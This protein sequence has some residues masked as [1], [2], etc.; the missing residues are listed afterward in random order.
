MTRNSLT[1]DTYFFF[2]GTRP[3]NSGDGLTPQTAWRD[4]QFG[5][6]CLADNADLRGKKLNL[7]NC[8]D[9][10]FVYTNKG[11][12]T[13]KPMIGQGAASDVRI[14]GGGAVF[15]CTDGSYSFVGGSLET[16][17]PAENVRFRL[18]NMKLRAPNG[19][20]INSNG[21]KIIVWEDVDFGP[22]TAAHMNALNPCGSIIA[23]GS[24]IAGGFLKNGYTISGRA[25][26]HGAGLC[27]A[28]VIIH[29]MR[30][31]ISRPVSFSYSF[32]QA[33]YPGGSVYTE[34]SEYVNASLVTGRK[35]DVTMG[36]FISTLGVT[37][38]GTVLGT[39]DPS[40]IWQH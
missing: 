21:S 14:D 27:S 35:W 24:P 2:D 20:G 19:G 28:Y 12:R 31:T 3:D 26:I 30:V 25:A 17:E 36:G 37:V 7:K 29:A 8:A 18:Q 5:W 6:E 22:M 32:L 40:S 23:D 4:L 13:F 9:P 38:P 33:A 16:G 1:A 34:F 10:T 15:E 11:L 39:V